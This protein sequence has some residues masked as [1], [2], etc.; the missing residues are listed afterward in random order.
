MLN[1]P[2]KVEQGESPDFMLTWPSGERAGLEVTRATTE[3]LQKT[4]TEMDKEFLR[5]EAKAKAAGIEVLPLPADEGVILMPRAVA[6][7][8]CIAQE[9]LGLMGNECEPRW[10]GQVLK[11][12]RR[13]LK[14]LA[15][16][17]AASYHNLLINN[18][19]D[20]LLGRSERK[21]AFD[22]VAEALN[23]LSARVK[24]S[25]REVSIIM[26]LDVEFDISG[27]RR[28]LPYTENEAS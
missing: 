17:R 21:R 11:A 13:K 6:E 18:D 25:F 27:N 8:M 23:D 10:C 3:D 20:V 24:P 4:L 15:K 1:F 7:P 16:F 14:K 12:V 9:P 26:S 28:F 2:I 22:T 19:A 5:C